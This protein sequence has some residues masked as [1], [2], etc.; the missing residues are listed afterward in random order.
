MV[1]AIEHA[2]EKLGA[3]FNDRAFHDFLL[4]S[5]ALPLDILEEQFGP[6]LEAAA[7]G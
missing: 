1:R 3:K 4:G 7:R 2:K 6:W 5:G